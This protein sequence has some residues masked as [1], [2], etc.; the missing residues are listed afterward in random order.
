MEPHRKCKHKCND[1][2]RLKWAGTTP[3]YNFRYADDWVVLTSTE[4]EAFRMKRELTKYFRQKL[5][6]E[7]SQEKT[8]VTDLRKEGYIFSVTSSRR[9]ESAKH[10][11]LQRG[12]NIWWENHCQIWNG[13]LRK[14]GICWSK[15]TTSNYFQSQTHRPPGY[16]MSIPSFW[17]WHSITSH[18]S[19]HTPIMQSTAE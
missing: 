7:L 5:K 1:T 3:K 2:R 11:T 10:R 19:V 16:N 12:R 15:Y 17:V 18:P 6:L 13:C 9:N 4:K 14:L 8:Y